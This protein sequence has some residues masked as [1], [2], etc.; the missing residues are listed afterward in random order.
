MVQGQE[1]GFIIFGFWVD[2]FLLFDV[3]IK[4]FIGDVVCGNMDVLVVFLV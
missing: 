3:D 4:V 2:V 1:F